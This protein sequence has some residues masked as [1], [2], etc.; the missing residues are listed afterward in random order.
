M[1]TLV[2]DPNLAYVVVVVGMW[3]AVTAVYMPGTGFFEFVAL[4]ILVGGLILLLSLPTNWLALLLL[5]IGVL[6]FILIP[7]FSMP[8]APLAIVGLA[9]QGA[10]GLFLFE[11]QAVSPMVLAFTL[12]ISLVYHQF[13]LM[14]TLRRLQTVNEQPIEREDRMIGLR[15]RVTKPIDPIGAVQ[16]D[17]ELWTATSSEMLTEGTSIVVIG[18]EGLSLIVEPLKRKDDPES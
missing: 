4:V 15:G 14:P 6:S 13:V 8:H 18:R 1:E 16:V 11:G 5:I 3:L 2:V 10:G 17:S 9:M 7:F 12:A